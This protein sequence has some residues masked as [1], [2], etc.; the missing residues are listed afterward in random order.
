MSE[1]VS[2]STSCS[3][4]SLSRIRQS[5]Y[6]SDKFQPGSQPACKFCGESRHTPANTLEDRRKHCK[7]FGKSCSKCQKQH[8][9]ASVC[10]SSKPQKTASVKEGDGG[11][12]GS[13]TRD[14]LYSNETFS[15]PDHSLHPTRVADL[16]PVVGVLRGQ[17]PVTSLPLPH[18][19]HDLSL[20]HI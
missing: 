10:L 19:V 2:L 11:L 20:I 13:I 6:K 17:G 5:T 14:N 1:T 18:H 12:V 16:L 9:F 8:H 15:Y 4:L 7:A 3:S